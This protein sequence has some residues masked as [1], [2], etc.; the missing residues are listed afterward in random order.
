MVVLQGHITE[1]I[2]APQVFDNDEQGPGDYSRNFGS[3]NA[4]PKKPVA[5]RTGALNSLEKKQKKEELIHPG[6]ARVSGRTVR[7]SSKK[8]EA[9]SWIMMGD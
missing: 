3:P 7:I 6:R 2:I 1:Y 8:P 9:F 5:S 4:S